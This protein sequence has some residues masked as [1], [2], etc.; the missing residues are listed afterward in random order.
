MNKIKKTVQNKRGVTILF[1]SLIVSALL[2]IALSLTSISL[3]QFIL[4]SSARESLQAFYRADT[5]IECAIYTDLKG[6]GL[7]D[8]DSGSAPYITCVGI[9]SQNESFS[10]TAGS[11]VGSI[12]TATY[13]FNMGGSCDKAK[14]SFS[15]KVIKNKLSVD[16]SSTTIFARGYNTCDTSSPN[17]VE[18]GLK[19]NY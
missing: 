16:T 7:A 11:A 1:A 10:S 12:S 18:R 15:L 13:D 9:N 2:A 5:A 4:A 17:R 14:P 8:P 3:Q 19:V 6:V